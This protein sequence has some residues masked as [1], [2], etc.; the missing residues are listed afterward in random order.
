MTSTKLTQR[1]VILTAI[2]L[3]A[4]G[5]G[6]KGKLVYPDQLLAKPPQVD[7]QQLGDSIELAVLLPSSDMTGKSLTDLTGVILGRRVTGVPAKVG[8]TEPYIP[9]SKVD[10]AAPVPPAEKRG[11][12]L[13][14]TDMH[15]KRGQGYQY[16]VQTVQSGSSLGTA[17]ESRPVV[18]HEPPASPT[19]KAVTLFGGFLRITPS[20]V[21]YND[22]VI[23]GF[24]LYR[25]EGLNGELVQIGTVAVG[26][27]FTD[28]SVTRGVVYQYQARTIV[29]LKDGEQIQS[30]L[31]PLVSA[32]VEDEPV[33]H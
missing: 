20:G 29:T 8:C 16:R 12:T 9:L 22:G 13:V 26:G 28:Q 24:T 33:L 31:S 1:A 4:S 21:P 30:Q 14:W 10:L 17:V 7:V 23:R 3:L 25:R 11:G 15:V 2:L 32:V 6:R 18:V 19:V 27:S 5:C